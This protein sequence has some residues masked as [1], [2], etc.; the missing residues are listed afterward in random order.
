MAQGL[1]DLINTEFPGDYE[2]FRALYLQ[3][4]VIINDIKIDNN[5]CRDIRKKARNERKNLVL[6]RQ[7]MV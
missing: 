1:K 3:K 2:V 6:A 7:G 4:Y 5:N